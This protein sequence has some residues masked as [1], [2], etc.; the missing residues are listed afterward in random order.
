MVNVFDK[1]ECNVLNIEC[2]HMDGRCKNGKSHL[3]EGA[4][5]ECILILF[6]PFP[7]ISSIHFIYGE[8]IGKERKEGK[9]NR[10]INSSEERS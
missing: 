4:F 7:L 3:L 10:G 6:F 2:R 5:N 1:R 9:N 8:E